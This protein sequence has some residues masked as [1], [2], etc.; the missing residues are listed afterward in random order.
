M[1]HKEAI[2]RLVRVA[3]SRERALRKAATEHGALLARAVATAIVVQHA[4]AVCELGAVIRQ[5]DQAPTESEG[6][7]AAAAAPGTGGGGGGGGAGGGPAAAS[8]APPP[9]AQASSECERRAA[10]AVQQLKRSLADAPGGG[11][12]VP[13]HLGPSWWPHGRAC[14]DGALSISTVEEL[15]A[16]FLRYAHS[17]GMLV[18]RIRLAA[19]DG[20][21]S[22]RRLWEVRTSSLVTTAVVMLTR[23]QLLAE[24]AVAPMEPV[25]AARPPREHLD[26]I[27]A[28]L[29]LS[30]EQGAICRELISSRRRR[31]SPI[32]ARCAELVQAQ[33]R[34]GP[35]LA[36]AEVAAE[37]VNELSGNQASYVFYIVVHYMALFDSVLTLQQYSDYSLAT[38]PYV[39]GGEEIDIVFD[40]A[41]A[42]SVGD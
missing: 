39:L 20:T 7:A 9:G 14:L 37:A 27:A 2:E 8:G 28:Q 18:P 4:E 29:R 32:N 34:G 30:P 40:I 42:A 31:C 21:E 24:C 25:A 41:I 36:A 11:S 5:L 33:A 12:A 17:I 6:A 23:P 3:T 16:V 35:G 13:P 19:H 38:W 26:Y 22:L 10:A 15:R 1:K